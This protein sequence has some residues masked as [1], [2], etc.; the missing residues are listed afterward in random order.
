MLFK[1]IRFLSIIAILVF[2]V[3]CDNNIGNSQ[4]VTHSY[5]AEPTGKYGV[6]FQDF[7][8][9]NKNAGVDPFYNGN[10]D[11]FSPDNQENHYHEI[12]ARIYYPTAEHGI[13]AYYKPEIQFYQNAFNAFMKVYGFITPEQIQE[14]GSLKSYSM[15]SASIINDKKFP[16]LLFSPGYSATSQHYENLI[17]ELV[18]QGY[19]VVAISSTF[20]NP[21][22]LSNGHI[23]QFIPYNG[24]TAAEVLED[25]DKRFIPLQEADLSFVFNEI[26]ILHNS[27]PIFSTMDLSHIGAFGHS[28]GG[29]TVAD[30]AHAH[31]EWFQAAASLDLHPDTDGA[32]VAPFKIP[33]MHE[34][35]AARN[36]PSKWTGPSKY[37]HNFSL[38]EN[39]YLVTLSPNE[40]DW[41]YSQHDDFSNTS[42]YQFMPVFQIVYDWDKK[43]GNPQVGNGNGWDRT[44]AINKYLVKFFDT[45]LKDQVEDGFVKCNALSINSYETKKPVVNTYIKCGRSTVVVV[46]FLQ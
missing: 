1:T 13:S 18:S 39:G 40:K 38:G 42:T 41:D 6:G 45:Y 27:N 35:A 2:I 23:V 34:I 25:I 7:H 22:E 11:D 29:K 46:P 10:N 44:H 21:V 12:V 9:V 15:P 14:L 36:V 4:N 26:Y 20:I 33:F 30:V 37:I 17:T 28:L 3:S 19:I 43:Q 31:P 5:L 8:W 16:V 24:T 32:S